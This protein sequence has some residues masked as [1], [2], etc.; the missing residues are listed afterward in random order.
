MVTNVVHV[1]SSQVES[2]DV[3]QINYSLT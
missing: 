1:Y 3:G 2:Q